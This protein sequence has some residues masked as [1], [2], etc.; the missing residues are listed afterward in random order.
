MIMKPQTYLDHAAATPCDDR[1]LEAMRPFLQD[2]FYNPSSM[3]QPAKLVKNALEDARHSLAMTIGAQ[4][5]E[6]VLASSATE[7]VNL[8]IHGVMRKSDGRILTTKIE[9]QAILKSCE[10]YTSDYVSIDKFGLI[11]LDDLK[12]K[13][14]DNTALITISYAN[15]ELGTVQDIKKI[16]EIIKQVRQHRESSNRR[17]PLYLHVDASQVAGYLDISV[18]RLGV[19]MMTLSST[20]CY[21]P[22]GAALLW[23]RSDIGLLPLINGGGQERNLVSGTENVASVVG[24]A[25]ALQIAEKKRKTTVN[26]VAEL[27]DKLQLLLITKI[28]DLVVNS[29]KKHSLANFLHISLPGLDGERAIIALDQDGVCVSTGSACSANRGT[30]SHVLANIGLSD[31]LISGSVRITLGRDTTETEINQVAEI[32][33]EVLQRERKLSF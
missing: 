18:N 28:P 33:G 17:L 7:S 3:Y 6:I 4:S 8:A 1:A 12:S 27:R 26:Q 32:M 11:K 5:S 19:D 30:K 25:R 9:H 24:F 14:T 15:S 22:R 2:Q 23:V 13:I 16:S 29:H 10:N 20:K 21:G 31:E